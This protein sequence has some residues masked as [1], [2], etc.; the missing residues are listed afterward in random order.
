MI[1]WWLD[2]SKSCVACYKAKKRHIAL[3]DCFVK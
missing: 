3:F 1:N 2:K